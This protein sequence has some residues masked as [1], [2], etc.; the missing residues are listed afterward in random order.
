MLY[1][2]GDVPHEHDRH[3]SGT[4]HGWRS[5][6]QQTEHST[7]TQWRKSLEEGSSSA[8]QVQQGVS[9]GLTTNRS[10]QQPLITTTQPQLG[11]AS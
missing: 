5:F 3:P 1:P 6:N 11:G 4:V 7:Q 10:S 8:S 2:H 9:S